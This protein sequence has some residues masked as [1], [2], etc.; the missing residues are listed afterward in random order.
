MEQ[1]LLKVKYDGCR[2]VSFVEV[3]RAEADYRLTIFIRHILMAKGVHSA[4][5]ACKPMHERENIALYTRTCAGM[6]VYSK[7]MYL[8]VLCPTL[9]PEG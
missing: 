8:L 1:C 9:L 4:Q 7:W 5:G 3:N 2:D 6:G